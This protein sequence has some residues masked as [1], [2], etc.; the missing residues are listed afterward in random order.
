M[1][2]V[3]VEV[4]FVLP[5]ERAPD[6]PHGEDAPLVP[7]LRRRLPPLDHDEE[8]LGAVRWE[9]R[10]ARRGADSRSRGA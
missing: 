2:G 7:L 4:L 10:R 1:R 6:D 3:P 9:L 8:T 5:P